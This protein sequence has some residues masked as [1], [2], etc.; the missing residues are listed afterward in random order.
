L[1]AWIFVPAFLFYIILNVIY[2]YLKDEQPLKSRNFI[3]MII[4]TSLIWNLLFEYIN[5]NS[6]SYEW[7]SLYSC[8]ITALTEYPALYSC[9]TSLVYVFSHYILVK[10]I[11]FKQSKLH[12]TSLQKTNSAVNLNVLFKSS[13]KVTVLKAM[14][15]KVVMFILIIGLYLFEATITSLV[16]FAGGFKCS[17]IVR[18]IMR[19]IHGGLLL[20]S[21][22]G[23][24]IAQITDL[25]INWRL[26]LKCRLKKY[27]IDDD[28]FYFR[29][30]S[31]FLF[32]LIPISVAWIAITNPRL[33]KISLVEVIFIFSWITVGGLFSLIVTS[34]KYCFVTKKTVVKDN[35]IDKV[36]SRDELRKHFIEFSKKEYSIENSFWKT[37]SDHYRTIT[38]PK[39][40][41]DIAELMVQ[42]YL[43]GSSSYYEINA[44]GKIIEKVLARIQRE[45]FDDALF[46]ELD[47]IVDVNL[48]DTLSRFIN[49]T[50]Y[51]NY[52]KEK[53]NIEAESSVMGRKKTLIE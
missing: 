26:I 34:F 44:P 6:V 23:V 37:D 25:I 19:Y 30:E 47:N 41:K 11:S 2:F 3:P 33:L 15:S 12:E 46:H 9:S 31:L 53:G 38:N 50:H 20:L 42:K 32:G 14:R 8:W 17:N 48:C 51:K 22:I 13:W 36:F 4:V 7:N 5:A 35:E 52:E 43:S 18:D 28:I 21:V 27:Y 24:V 16:I 40:R 1:N 39:K 49:T 29:L 10:A 45:E